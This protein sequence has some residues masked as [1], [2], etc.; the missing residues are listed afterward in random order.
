VARAR[1]VLVSL[2]DTPAASFRPTIFEQ[3]VLASAKERRG[4]AVEALA[5]EVL[6]TKEPSAKIFLLLAEA[7]SGEKG[8]VEDN[9]KLE[10]QLL[11]RGME[12]NASPTDEEFALDGLLRLDL[13]KAYL[14]A[15]DAAR[16]VETLEALKPTD[17]LDAGQI[18][19]ALAPAYAKAG[20]ATRAYEEYVLAVAARPTPEAAAGL[21]AAAKASGKTSVEADA[22]VW[23]ARDERAV[24]A[25]DFTLDAL[26]GAKGV[27]L[28]AYRGKVVLLNFWYPS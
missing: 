8:A 13:G 2:K 3:Y 22:A 27:S 21:D 12:A 23:K 26:D 17:D 5:A 16:A 18:A 15:G 19:F 4:Q 10:I 25:A 14:R 11:T 6:A 1:T 24:A 7:V 28:S 20:N 9:A